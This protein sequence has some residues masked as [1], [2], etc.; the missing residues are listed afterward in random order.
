M[1]LCIS[2]ASSS[3]KIQDG[4]RTSMPYEENNDSS[5][6]P[7]LGSL[8]SM[9]GSKGVN[10]DSAMLCQGYGKEGE[11]LCGVFDGHGKF[12]HRVSQLVRSNLPSLLLNKMK[13]LDHQRVTAEAEVDGSQNPVSCK[14]NEPEDSETSKKFQKWKEAF[15]SSFRVMD[16]EIKLQQNLDNSC[17]GTTAVVVVKQGE[18]L[19]IANLGDSRA[20][21]GTITE[22]GIKAIQLTTDLKPGVPS[23]A[24]RIRAC[25]GRVLALKQE[26]NIERVWLPHV[27][28]PG[29]AM[30]RAF[31]DFIL[32]DH[33]IIATPDVSH[34]R[35]TSN[36]QFVVLATDGVWDVL[37]NS[38]V[39]SIVWEAESAQAAAR[40]VNEAASAMWRKKFPN[41]K[42]DDCTVVCLFLQENIT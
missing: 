16:K 36:D 7:M 25:G 10:Q 2:C 30:S 31:G 26:P 17:S 33:G 39:A 28:L 34:H 35:L 8:H 38:E 29:L 11:A 27:D 9:E 14:D 1:G 21:L 41:A 20:V 19:F 40:V 32:K 42:R 13:A 5:G 15:V 3:H 22:D 18:D 6:I 4:N 12:G 24:E 23:E 37:S